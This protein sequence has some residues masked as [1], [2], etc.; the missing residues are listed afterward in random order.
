MWDTEIWMLPTV[1]LMHPNWSEQ[2]LKYRFERLKKAK[3]YAQASGYSGARFFMLY[4]SHFNKKIQLITTQ[5]N[6]NSI[7]NINK[8]MLAR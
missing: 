4:L 8:K 3:Q 5:S 1:L 6:Y 2:I 7:Q